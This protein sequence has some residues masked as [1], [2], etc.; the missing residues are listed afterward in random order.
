MTRDIN[1]LRKKT[2]FRLDHYFSIPPHWPI[3]LILQAMVAQRYWKFPPIQRENQL[4]ATPPGPNQLT[5]AQPPQGSAEPARRSGK[6]VCK[7]GLPKSGGTACTERS[8]LDSTAVTFLVQRFGATFWCPSLF[9]SSFS[10]RPLHRFGGLRRGK[11]T[12]TAFHP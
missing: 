9:I 10:F 2:N 4:F 7:G 11:T 1:D 12:L 3:Q 8:R 5:R 6:V